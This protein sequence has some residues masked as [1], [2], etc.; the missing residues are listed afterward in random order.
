M[1][2]K[3]IAALRQER[4]RLLAHL[5]ALKEIHGEA[6]EE[7]VTIRL[8][9]RVKKAI[10]KAV[11]NK[12]HSKRMQ[13]KVQAATCQMDLFYTGTEAAGEKEHLEQTPVTHPRRIA[14]AISPTPHSSGSLGK[15]QDMSGVSE[16]LEKA[17][18]CHGYLE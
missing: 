9:E 3:M 6:V 15:G 11:I 7:Y 8:G 16:S 14:R 12:Q 10:D 17:G 4:E 13:K 5:Q 1:D 18:P 2:E